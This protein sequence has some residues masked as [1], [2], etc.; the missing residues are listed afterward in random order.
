MPSS[1]WNPLLFVLLLI[2]ISSTFAVQPLPGSHRGTPSLVNRDQLARSSGYIF[3]GT[4]KAIERITPRGKDG[5]A[6]ILITFHVD[7]AIR[8]VRAGQTL[9]VH[10][11]AGLWQS[12]ERYRPGE[13]VLLFLY[14]PSKLGLTSPVGGPMGRFRVDSG[15][16]VVVPRRIGGLSPDPSA[17]ARFR[18]R[19][20]MNIPDFVRAFG[21]ME[22]E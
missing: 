21:L 3:A 15:G 14:P 2:L 19:T 1:V 17:R 12:G 11:W 13:R 7:K 8:G 18:G 6:T 4:V 5:V 20:R 16:R 9:T 10:E 22:A